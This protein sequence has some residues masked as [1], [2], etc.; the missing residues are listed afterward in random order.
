MDRELI[1]DIHMKSTDDPQLPVDEAFADETRTQDHGVMN[2]FEARCEAH[3]KAVPDFVD[4]TD[5]VQKA[6][7]ASQIRAGRAIVFAPGDVCSI[8]VNERESGLLEDLKKVL[9]R[10]KASNGHESH[11]L[12]GSSSVVLPIVDGRLGLGTWQR[13]LLVELT[14]AGA[15]PVDIE[16]IGER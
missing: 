13:I 15:R 4:V 12:L 7:D 10:L 11:A 9:A 2:T 8:M 5:E 14:Q 16:I 1:L 3:T 6:V